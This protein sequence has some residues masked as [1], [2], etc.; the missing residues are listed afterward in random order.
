M[1][2]LSGGGKQAVEEAT[3]NIGAGADGGIRDADENAAAAAAAASAAAGTSSSQDGAETAQEMSMRSGF[4]PS[5][6]AAA[7]ATRP[8]AYHAIPMGGARPREEGQQGQVPGERGEQTSR[9]LS[10]DPSDITMSHTIASAYLVEG[11]EDGGEGGGRSMQPME[12]SSEPVHEAEV[13][14]TLCGG[15]WGFRFYGFVRMLWIDNI[16]AIT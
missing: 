13:V 10:N 7:L 14:Q 11:E 2:K 1:D 16:R 15:K 5:A 12:V 4:A 8:G 9:R 3:T 6:A